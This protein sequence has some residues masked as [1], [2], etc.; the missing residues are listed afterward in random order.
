MQSCWHKRLL[1]MLPQLMDGGQ[2]EE[3][4]VEG[5]VA[6]EFDL[7]EILAEQVTAPL[8]SKEEQLRQVSA[9]GAYLGVRLA[10]KECC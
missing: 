7:R 10:H 9:W 1:Q 5:G 8:T 2:P 3:E 6:E 4:D